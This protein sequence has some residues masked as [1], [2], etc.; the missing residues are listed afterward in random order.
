MIKD[1]M[2]LKLIKLFK[3]A[4]IAGLGAA[5]A[6]M[7]EGLQGVDFGEWTPIAV[8]GFAVV[9]NAIRQTFRHTEDFDAGYL[10]GYMDRNIEDGF[11]DETGD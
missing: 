4:L 1:R 10:A 7:A 5:M 3:G 2:K 11:H 9:I 6:Y 8:A